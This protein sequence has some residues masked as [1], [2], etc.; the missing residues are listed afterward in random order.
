MALS[1]EE[2]LSL[3]KKFGKSEKDTGSA[4]VQ[5][6]LL[7]TRIKDLTAHLQKNPQDAAARRSL[8]LLV[9]KRRGLLSYLLKNNPDGYSKLIAELGLRK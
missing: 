9:G 8:F 2:T 6:A 3:I 1:K 4:E 5:I 7:S